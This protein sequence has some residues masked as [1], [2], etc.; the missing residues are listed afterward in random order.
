MVN[1]DVAAGYLAPLDSYLSKW[2]GWSEYSAAAKAAAKSNNGHTYGVPM[3][4]DTRGLWY[5]KQLLAKAGI[6]A[7]LAPEDVG[8]RPGRRRS[9]SRR[10][11]RRHSDQRLLRRGSLAKVHEHAGLRDVPVRDQQPAVQHHQ[12]Q[13]GRGRSGLRVRVERLQDGLQPGYSAPSPQAAVEP[14]FLVTSLSNPLPQGKLAIDLDGSWVSSDWA[15][16]SKG[17]VAPWPQWSKVMGVAAMPT[18]NGQAG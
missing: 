14:Q 7:P 12:Q 2:S 17:G 6:A 10:R 1:S 4:T 5:N 15:P 9:R 8:R 13:V 11:P 3:G 18:Q 16:A